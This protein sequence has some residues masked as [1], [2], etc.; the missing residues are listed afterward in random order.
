MGEPGCV[1]AEAVCQ[2]DGVAG[3]GVTGEGVGERELRHEGTG[4]SVLGARTS[5]EVP[6]GWLRRA[7]VRG[8]VAEVG[9]VEGEEPR[10]KCR[11]AQLV[12]ML[13]VVQHIA[14]LLEGRA[15][16]V[17]PSGPVRRVRAGG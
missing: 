13:L 1:G 8:L 12:D 14:H 15:G 17:L 3:H 5:G 9:I 11:A 16:V 10:R 2:C 6:V 7:R 4:A